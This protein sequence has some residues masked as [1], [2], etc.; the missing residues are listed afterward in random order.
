MN[1][2]IKQPQQLAQLESLSL[3]AVVADPLEVVVALIC[4]VSF[5]SYTSI[6]FKATI[7]DLTNAINAA[8]S[9]NHI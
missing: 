9:N 7:I 3:F 1:I 4:G 6:S 2:K 8:R 5:F